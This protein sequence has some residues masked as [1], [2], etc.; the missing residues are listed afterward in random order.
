V[1]ADLACFGGLIFIFAGPWLEQRQQLD[2]LLLNPTKGR[3]EDVQVALL[4]KGQ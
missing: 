2:F 3:G 1:K 4:L